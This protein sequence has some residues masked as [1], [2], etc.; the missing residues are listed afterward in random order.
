MEFSSTNNGT[1]RI[2][3][4]ASRPARCLQ[5]SSKGLHDGQSARGDPLPTATPCAN[6]LR[7]VTLCNDEAVRSGRPQIVE[8]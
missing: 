8:H 2:C 7:T 3:E 1:A 4:I 5:R 6:G